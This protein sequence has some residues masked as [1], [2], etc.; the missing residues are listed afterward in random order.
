MFGVQR[1]RGIY[2]SLDFDLSFRAVDAET[3]ASTG[4]QIGVT[5]RVQI[6]ARPATGKGTLHLTTAGENTRSFDAIER[7]RPTAAE[8]ASLAGTY[9]SDELKAKLELVVRRGRL[10][11]ASQLM[12]PVAPFNSVTRDLHFTEPRL[13]LR[14]VR[15]DAGAVTG[16]R[17]STRRARNIWF[18]RQ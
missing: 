7:Q 16:L 4:G 18:S 10:A 17:V 5:A 6:P 9:E 1:G 8:L 13:M 12:I 3:F 14:V 2:K 11:I 15:S